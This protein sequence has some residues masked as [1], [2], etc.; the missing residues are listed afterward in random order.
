[1]VECWPE[2]QFRNQK[3]TIKKTLLTATTV[4]IKISKLLFK[5]QSQT[6]PT[7]LC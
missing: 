3:Q 5:T 7:N 1:M 2:Y 6:K 4:N